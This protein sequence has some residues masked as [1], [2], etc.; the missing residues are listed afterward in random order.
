MTGRL[1]ASWG[2][3]IS[4]TTLTLYAGNS[5]S[6]RNADFD[7]SFT[8]NPNIGISGGTDINFKRM[9][10]TPSASPTVVFSG[11]GSSNSVTVNSQGVAILQ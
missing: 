2:V 10:G 3:N 11:L 9:T 8:F 6:Q 1:N 7:E 5:F 4:G